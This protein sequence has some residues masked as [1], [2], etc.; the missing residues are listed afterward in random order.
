MFRFAVQGDEAE[1]STNLKKTGSIPAS[2][3][4]K[5]SKKRRKSEADRME[6]KWNSKS[7]KKRRESTAE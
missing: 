4:I 2:V 5:S 3:S 6:K 1:W 7:R